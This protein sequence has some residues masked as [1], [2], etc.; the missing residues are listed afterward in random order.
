MGVAVA[1]SGQ[2]ELLWAAGPAVIA[3]Q[4]PSG[5]G[6]GSSTLG[7]EWWNDTEVQRELALSPDKIKRINDLYARRSQDVRALIHEYQRQTDELDKMTRARVVDENTYLMQ[8]MRVEAVR[9]RLNESRL[10]MLYRF[11]RELSPEQHQ[12][13][14]EIRDRRFNRAGQ[15]RSSSPA[16]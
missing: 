8:V 7:W 10:V 2:N 16:R 1:S 6:P 12:K 15:G 14:Q 11:Y 13:L 5:R 4:G 3:E 9:A